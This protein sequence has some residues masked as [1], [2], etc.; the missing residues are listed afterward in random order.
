MHYG[1]NEIT[2]YA[3]K[4][5]DQSIPSFAVAITVE[6]KLIHAVGCSKQHIHFS[7]DIHCEKTRKLMHDKAFTQPT[8]LWI[9]LT[10]FL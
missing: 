2:G 8:W 10:P 4:I 9:E 5:T 7:Y 1:C 6:A 3:S